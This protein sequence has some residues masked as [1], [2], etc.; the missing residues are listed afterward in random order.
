MDTKDELTT[1]ERRILRMLAEDLTLR[2][3]G[4]ELH[5]SIKAIRTHVHS[6]CSK[7]RVSCRIEAV[8][9]APAGIAPAQP[10]PGT[11]ESRR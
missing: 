3:I 10:G 4:S 1:L 2:E 11:G 7:L 8:N 9:A 5:V 6:I